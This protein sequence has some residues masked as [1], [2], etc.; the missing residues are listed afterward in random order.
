MRPSIQVC[1]QR[2]RDDERIARPDDEVGVLAGFERAD[3]AVDAELLRRIERDELEGLLRRHAA[4]LH[5]LGR[6]VIQV[7]AQLGVVGVERH[8]DARRCISAPL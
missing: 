4:V 5:G 3:P 7:P 1:S 8:D 2:E 6:F